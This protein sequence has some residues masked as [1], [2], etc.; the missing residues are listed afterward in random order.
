MA[1]EVTKKTFPARTL[2]YAVSI[3]ALTALSTA[4]CK[5]TQ[6]QLVDDL[7]YFKD[8]ITAVARFNFSRSEAVGMW[9]EMLAGFASSTAGAAAIETL[10]R[11][12]STGLLSGATTLTVGTGTLGI[13]IAKDFVWILRGD[14][15]RVALM[16]CLRKRASDAGTTPAEITVGGNTLI[17]YREGL[18]ATS[19]RDGILISGNQARAVEGLTLEASGSRKGSLLDNDRFKKVLL[20]YDGQDVWIEVTANEASRKLMRASP[21]FAPAAAMSYAVLVGNF[22]GGSLKVQMDSR[23]ESPQEGAEEAMLDFASYIFPRCLGDRQVTGKLGTTC[24]DAEATG[25]GIKMGAT[26]SRQN[27]VAAASHTGAEIDPHTALLV[28]GNTNLTSADLALKSRIELVGFVVVVK[29][30]SA[31]QAA[32]A[33]RADVVVISESVSSASLGERLTNV[34][35]GIVCSEPAL[36]DDLELT[37]EVWTKDF[38]DVPSAS[39]VFV[40]VAHHPITGDLQG[41]IP[42]LAQPGK[43]VWGWPGGEGLILARTDGAVPR[44]AVFAYDVGTRLASGEAATGRRVGFFAGE[45]TPSQF[46]EKAWSIFSRAVHW[47]SKKPDATGYLLVGRKPLGAGDANLAAVM[48]A[49][50]VA[51]EVVTP[52]TLGSIASHRRDVLVVSESVE[53][54]DVKDS[55]L[56]STFT[57]LVVLEPS[58]FDDLGM[59]GGSWQTDY[60]DRLQETSI[61]IV[62]SLH[63][64]SAGLG[65]LQTVVNPG[66]KFVWGKPAN[67]AQIVAHLPGAPQQS[68]IFS[69]VRGQ[70]MIGRR[71]PARRV[72][73]FLGRDAPT[74]LTVPGRRLLASALRFA[75]EPDPATAVFVVG[76]APPSPSDAAIAARLSQLGMNVRVILDA[77]LTN[78]TADAFDLIV[79]SES[80]ASSSIGDKVA[81]TKT[82]VLMLEVAA[83]DETGMVASAWGIDQGDIENQDA[84]EIVNF[85]HPLAGGLSKG[86]TV[87]ATGPGKLLWGRP[88]STA[89]VVAT[90]KAQAEKA[91]VFAFSPGDMMVS[92]RA[93]GRRLGWFAGRD[94]P[95]SFSTAGWQL[96]D[97]AATWASEK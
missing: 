90:V 14:L 69:Y 62:D 37:G 40:A 74:K 20:S 15:A 18:W 49:T 16:D 73:F 87:I 2:S 42:V 95:A 92:T 54:V 94:L 72:G 41:S 63:V 58:L 12:C 3:C 52:A 83:L 93:P 46:T 78:T 65:G 33:E 43:L 57:P 80:C 66:G 60:G 13:G 39:N 76:T 55:V 81:A 77:E 68:A 11:D 51:V 34:A 26:I 7:V 9:G 53:S 8:D 86:V 25:S 31:V 17:Q 24:F 6:P 22:E 89:A 4:S 97:A 88:P 23:L 75:I 71:A 21:G 28:V 56:A 82:G 61:E 59:T 79:V 85:R 32:D 84:V 70:A 30:G 96:F 45:A 67:G 1:Y 64:L 10:F 5:K 27:L 47:A 91:T 48:V 50:G 36:F 44:A 35:T 29:S 19:P 38:G